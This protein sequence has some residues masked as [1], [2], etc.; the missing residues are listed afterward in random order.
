MTTT[1]GG[2]NAASGPPD[3][4]SYVAP[5]PRVVSVSP[6]SG[7]VSG[8]TTVTITGTGFTGTTK[9]AFGAVAAVSFAVVS[10][11]EITAVTPAQPAGTRVVYVTTAG[12]VTSPSAGPSDQFT[13]GS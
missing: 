7:P 1:L 12:G 2:T 3:S 11:T 13:Y 10:D 5:I 6:Q 9:V 8:G 4:F